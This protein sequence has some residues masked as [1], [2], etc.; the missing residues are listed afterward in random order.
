MEFIKK[1]YR[2]GIWYDE[3]KNG[4]RIQNGSAIYEDIYQTE[5]DAKEQIRKWVKNGG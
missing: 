3:D 5:E 2:F 1:F 4:Y